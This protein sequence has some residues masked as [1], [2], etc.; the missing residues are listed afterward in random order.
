MTSCGS[1][2]SSGTWDKDA[3]PPRDAEELNKTMA[4]R[5]DSTHMM[6]RL[7]GHMGQHQ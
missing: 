3:I 6:G 7:D 2:S 5:A 4:L 1:V